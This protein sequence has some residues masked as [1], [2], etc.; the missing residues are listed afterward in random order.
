MHKLNGNSLETLISIVNQRVTNKIIQYQIEN[1]MGKERTNE[2]Y[3][4]D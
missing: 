2:L 4:I 3:Q 1:K